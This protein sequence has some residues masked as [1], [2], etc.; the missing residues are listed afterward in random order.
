MSNERSAPSVINIAAYKFVAIDDLMTRRERLRSLCRKWEL[1]G[2][3]L[4]SPEGINLFLAGSREGI[5]GL[6]DVLQQD[7]ALSDLDVKQSLSATQPFRRMLVKSKREIIPFGVDG[8]DP[9]RQTSPKLPPRTLKTWLD[10]NRDVVLLDV[11]NDF[12][13][14]F[15]TFIT[16]RPIG[17][18]RFR[19][20][21]EAAEQLP[22]DLKD[23]PVVMFCTGGIR[24]EKAGPYL[25][26]LGF[27]EVYQLDGGILRY[28]EEC[29]GEHFDGDCFVFDERI[30]VDADLSPKSA[31]TIQSRSP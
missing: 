20:F 9:G 15:G 17:I 19:H 29:G 7:P 18:P 31:C 11:R 14:N 24:C 13:I 26:R 5:D 3:I 6:L 22:D 2:T 1:R 12:E 8:I 21:A 16:A 27:R 10:K 4:L 28:F 23:R 30:A 25:E